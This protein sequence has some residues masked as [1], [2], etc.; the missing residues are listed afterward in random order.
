M[1]GWVAGLAKNQFT[2]EVDCLGPDET[3][4]TKR[5][6]VYAAPDAIASAVI[7]MVLGGE[8]IETLE[9]ELDGKQIC[10]FYPPVTK[11][12]SEE[13]MR[14]LDV[15]IGI[16]PEQWGQ[17]YNTLSDLDFKVLAD[18]PGQNYS[19]KAIDG[20]SEFPWTVSTAQGRFAVLDAAAQNAVTAQ[21]TSKPLE[22]RFSPVASNCRRK[23]LS[24]HQA[25]T[26][27]LFLNAWKRAGRKPLDVTRKEYVAAEE[28]AQHPDMFNLS[29]PT[30]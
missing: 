18:E 4:A 22:Q 6:F 10:A 7:L 1:E 23:G 12:W 14:Q 16:R 28:L 15:L 17:H 19:S 9:T 13:G 11:V 2:R 3:S 27:Y 20:R 30:Y 29:T 25:I 8:L 5:R 26:Q 24:S 21:T